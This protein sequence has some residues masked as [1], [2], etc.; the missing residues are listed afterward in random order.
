MKIEYINLPPPRPIWWRKKKP[1]SYV[2][3]YKP[4]ELDPLPIL[5]KPRGMNYER[6][7]E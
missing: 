6:K 1:I 4:F 5:L 2:P 3:A 7:E